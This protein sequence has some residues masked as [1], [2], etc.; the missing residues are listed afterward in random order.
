MAEH[1]SILSGPQRSVLRWIADGCPAG[2][3]EG[4]THRISAA[5][6]RTRGLVT[7]SRRGPDAEITAKGNDFLRQTDETEDASREPRA[8]VLEGVVEPKSF[9]PVPRP[10]AVSLPI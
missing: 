7:I 9:P 10:L 8:D 3:M 2:V 4:Y 6:L 1:T 5:A